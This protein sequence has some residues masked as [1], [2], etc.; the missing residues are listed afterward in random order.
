[1][2]GGGGGRGER[3]GHYSVAFAENC[4]NHLFPTTTS[5]RES[6]IGC[7]VCP[8]SQCYGTQPVG[9][10][11]EQR[12]STCAAYSFTRKGSERSNKYAQG[13]R[14][15][16]KGPT[17]RPSFSDLCVAIALAGEQRLNQVSKEQ[18]LKISRKNVSPYVHCFQP[19]FFFSLPKLGTLL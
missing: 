12:G 13:R 15:I 1:M 19:A 2:G 9:T 11:R 3:G 4:Q 6:F 7:A 17:P 10:L 14:K 16:Q 5:L 18:I 8:L